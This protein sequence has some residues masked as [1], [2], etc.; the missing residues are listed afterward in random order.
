[1]TRQLFNVLTTVGAEWVMYLLIGLSV[2]SIALVFER[3]VFFL[4]FGPA[5]DAA[6]IPLLTQ[7]RFEEVRSQLEGRFGLAAAV[8]LAAID[9]APGG[10][11]SVEE[12]M[13]CVIA[14]EKPAYERFLSFLG[15]LGN[16]APFLGLF[17]T[18][19]GIIKAFSDL[20]IGGPKAAGAAAVMSGISEALVATAIGIFVAIPAVVAFNSY[21]RWLKTII[22]RTQALG[23][24]VIA[25]LQKDEVRAAAL[26]AVEHER[27]AV[28]NPPAMHAQSGDYSGHVERRGEQR[29]PSNR[30]AL[31]FAGNV[32]PRSSSTIETRRANPE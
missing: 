2:F 3:L 32:G 23:H 20:A 25:H 9:A 19:V 31:D 4:R 5:G 22:G 6:L 10:P 28:R 1:M 30:E 18:V 11:K 29:E 24:A 14:R 15:T 27:R 7:G 26:E 12:V 17:G 13:A 8:T 21:N 16:N